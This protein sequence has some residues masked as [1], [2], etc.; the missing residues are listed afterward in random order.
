M[1]NSFGFGGHNASLLIGR[2]F[3]RRPGLTALP[4]GSDRSVLQ[5]EVEPAQAAVWIL[6]WRT[7]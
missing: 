6:T 3:P 7:L 1:S 4:A 5:I 2:Y